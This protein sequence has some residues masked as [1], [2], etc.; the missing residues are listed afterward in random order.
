[1]SR[2]EEEPRVER[3]TQEAGEATDGRLPQDGVRSYALLE[4]DTMS[5]YMSF[6][7]HT[8]AKS[9]LERKTKEFVAIAA[10]LTSGCRNCLEGHLEKAISSGAT[11]EEISEVIA[12]TLGV[13]AATIVDRSD[14]AAAS[15]G[16]GPD[17][18]PTPAR[19]EG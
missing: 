1:M 12:I 2:A 13:G 4:K 19:V 5:L 6:Y 14:I 15:L 3:V 9:C 8:Y 16:L 7:K 11:R 17:D 18:W 10:S